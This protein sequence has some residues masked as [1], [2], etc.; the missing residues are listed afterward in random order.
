MI[1][2][3]ERDVLE[4]RPDLLLWQTGTNS[5]LADG[6]IEAL[7]EDIDRGIDRA[8]SA[9]IDV[10]LMTPQHSPRFESV[11]NKAAYLE[12]IALIAAVNRVPVLRRYEM[13]KHWVASGE[14]TEPEM[15]NPDGL[16]LTDRS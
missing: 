3:F 2:R 12:N 10:V 15:I 16:H 1:A 14:M 5:A 11:R 9:G 8:H 7:V 13:M 4:E 6:D